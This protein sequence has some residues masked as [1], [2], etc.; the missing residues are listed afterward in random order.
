MKPSDDSTSDADDRRTHILVASEPIAPGP[1]QEAL[2]D[3]EL[4]HARI[5]IVAPAYNDSALAFWVSDADE[6]IGEAKRAGSATRRSAESAGAETDVRIGESDPLQAIADAL[7]TFEA[8][9]IIVFRHGDDEKAHSESLATED[10]MQRF[11]LPVTE[12]LVSRP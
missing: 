1:L 12:R 3:D 9:R 2:G 7:A 8:E 4:R 11:L 6:A 10:V 5:R